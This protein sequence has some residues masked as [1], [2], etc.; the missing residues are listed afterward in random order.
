MKV[1]THDDMLATG[2]A[3]RREGRTTI[4]PDSDPIAALTWIQASALFPPM[5]CVLSIGKYQ[6][7]PQRCCAGKYVPPFE[8]TEE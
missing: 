2:L 7:E 3:P 6:G 1:H 8:F 4:R 5:S